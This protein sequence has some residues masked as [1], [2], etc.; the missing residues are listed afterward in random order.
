MIKR[1][2][3]VMVL[4][5]AASCTGPRHEKVQSTAQTEATAL[6][7]AKPE[8]P[9]NPSTRA[10]SSWKG[11]AGAALYDLEIADLDGDGLK[12]IL[13]MSHGD[14]ALF[15][16]RNSGHRTFDLVQKIEEV[17]YHPNGVRALDE[18]GD[19]VADSLVAACEGIS[20]V[21]WYEKNHQGLFFLSQSLSTQ[22]PPFSVAVGDFNGDG[23]KELLLGG[24]PRP[25]DRVEIVY[26][27][28]DKS[29]LQTLKTGYTTTLYPKAGDVNGDGK[30]D[31]VVMNS[32][33]NILSLFLNQGGGAFT[34]QALEVPKGVAREV[35]LADINRDGKPDYLLAFEVGKKAVI[36]YN[37]GTGKIARQE[38]FEAPAFGYR[39]VGAYVTETY[40][41][42]ALAEEGRVFLALKRRNEADWTTKEVAAE[43]YPRKLYF[44]DMDNDGAIDLVFANSGSGTVQVEFNILALFGP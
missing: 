33:R 32:H 43:S 27:K 11:R 8:I 2:L 1:L 9:P 5:M 38:E 25:T 16:L 30:E 7:A 35:M 10:G 23:R 26:G 28:G 14:N 20:Q 12:D 13:A 18:N 24:G 3:I 36:L 41:L 6:P 44:Q 29:R 39:A 34:H 19:G 15:I 21:Q 31:I 17:G 4:L 37:D 22:S 42:M 40:A